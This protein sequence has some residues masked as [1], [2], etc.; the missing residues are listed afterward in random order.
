VKIYLTNK[1]VDNPAGGGNQFLKALRYEFVKKGL[2]T[3]DPL[4]ADIVLFNSHQNL[5]L[6]HQ[7]KEINRNAYFVHRLDGPMRLYNNMNDQRDY[8]AYQ[9][10]TDYADAIIFQSEW[11]KQANIKLGLDISGKKDTVIHN[12]PDPGIFY[13]SNQKQKNEKTR[14]IASSW[15]DN[16]RKG[17]LTYKYLDETLDFNKYEFFFMGRSP[18]AF[19]SIVSLGALGSQEVADELRKS[20]IFITASENDPCSNSLIEAL[21]S[22]LPVLALNSGGHPELVRSG[23]LL[24]NKKEDIINKLENICNN[25]RN[26]QTGAP[27][28]TIESAAKEYLLFFDRCISYKDNKRQ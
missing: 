25:Y 22:G 17:F 4:Q 21:A 9:M 27:N 15:S 10:N 23:G 18:V 1:L 12:A 2:C 13:A 26:Y 19:K 6:V 24:Y 16:I 14:L 11:S 28:N 3:E 8:I 7:I 20:D 5:G